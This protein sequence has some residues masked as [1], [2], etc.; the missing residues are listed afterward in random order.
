MRLTLSFPAEERSRFAAFDSALPV[1]PCP[2]VSPSFSLAESSMI[3][4][5]RG[6]SFSS[7]ARMSGSLK[8]YAKTSSSIFGSFT[9]SSRKPKISSNASKPSQPYMSL[10]I[11]LKPRPSSAETGMIFF[12]TSLM[13]GTSLNLSRNAWDEAKFRVNP[14][15]RK[16]W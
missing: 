2:V 8:S 16:L 10:G 12:P 7:R 15:S 4:R 6:P 3:T 9:A 13:S 5:N 1:A 11:F 14:T